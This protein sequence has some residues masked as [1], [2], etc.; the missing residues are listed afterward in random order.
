MIGVMSDSHDNCNA[1]QQAVRF[2]KDMKCET[3]IHAGDFVAP[4]AAHEL[5][6]LQ[7]PVKAVFG[8]CDGEK[9]GLEKV[10]HSFGEIK[11]APFVF[12]HAGRKILITHIHVSVDKY[13]ASGKYDAIIFGHTHK[14]EI[15]QV[16][17]TLLI[18]PGETG[19]WLTGKG[20]VALWDPVTL[21]A[22]IIP[23]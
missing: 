18:N 8:N 12:S 19:G 2:F 4:F 11:E 15:K 17:N 10:I 5:E 1:I 6:H 3:V 16:H 7:C 22:E 14:P 23:L 13:A 9:K 21:E 20:T